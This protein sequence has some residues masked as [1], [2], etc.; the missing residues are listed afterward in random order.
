MKRSF[1]IFLLLIL[2]GLAVGQTMPDSTILR[3]GEHDID[4][5]LGP[6]EN[7]IYVVT[8]DF[9]DSLTVDLAVFGDGSVDFFLLNSYTAYQTY[10]SNQTEI[11]YLDY[12]YSQFWSS[13]IEYE[14]TSDMD[15]TLYI[16]IDNTAY[17]ESGATPIGTVAV[18]GKITITKSPWI[19]QAILLTIALLIII[20]VVFVKFTFK[21]K[22]HTPSK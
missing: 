7:A 8:M 11:M 12:P 2:T 14:Y 9:G 18:E 20:I 13:L 6:N 17:T 1:A 22:K 4:I 15:D 3:Y 10:S 5:L 16:I 19:L 21:P